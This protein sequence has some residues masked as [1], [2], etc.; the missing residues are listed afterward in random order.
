M[1][2]CGDGVLLE[3]E[4]DDGNIIN[5]DGCSDQCKIEP[6]FVCS[7]Q[8]MHTS[9]CKLETVVDVVDIKVL[10]VPEENKL[11]LELDVSPVTDAYQSYE[12]G[13]IFEFDHPGITINTA[14]YAD[15][16]LII[17]TSYTEDLEGKDIGLSLKEDS[18]FVPGHPDDPDAETIYTTS[19]VT[20]K[21][22]STF[23]PIKTD[24]NLDAYYYSEETYEEAKKVESAAVAVSATSLTSGFFCLVLK[25]SLPLVMSVS[26]LQL[27]FFSLATIDGMHPAA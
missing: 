20:F 6:Y 9:A 11:T 2:I 26:S 3:R 17:E 21:L 25:G 4:C 16:K 27:V 22:S 18:L 14:S 15:G 10:K 12:L 24:N 19:K 8:E 5:G 23:L 1:E 13:Q 7:N